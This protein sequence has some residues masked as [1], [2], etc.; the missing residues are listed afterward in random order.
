MA[1][2]KDSPGNQK[3]EALKKSL[4]EMRNDFRN[5]GFNV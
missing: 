5:N 1:T 3:N 4:E 2:I